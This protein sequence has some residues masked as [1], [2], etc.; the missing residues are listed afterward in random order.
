MKKLIFTLLFTLIAMAH[1][2]SQSAMLEVGMKAPEWKFQDAD[3]KDFTMNSWPGKVLQINYIDPDDSDLNDAFNDAL[4]KAINIDKRINKDNFM[5]SELSIL[6]NMEA[7]RLIR[8][9]A[10]NKAKKYDATVL[11]DYDATFRKN[12]DFRVTVT[13][14]LL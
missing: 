14:L 12:G 7:K 8:M 6:I 2:C 3:G 11:F 10:G 9:I 4:D 5:D 1:V 13:V